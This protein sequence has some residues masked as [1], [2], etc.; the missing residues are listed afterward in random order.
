MSTQMPFSFLL[1]LPRHSRVMCWSLSSPLAAALPL[2]HGL[3]STAADHRPV[4][5]SRYS[6]MG[7]WVWWA[8][9]VINK[10]DALQLSLQSV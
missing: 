3:E 2:L 1:V 8:S 4:R 7:V 10:Q 5:N 9:V 6:R